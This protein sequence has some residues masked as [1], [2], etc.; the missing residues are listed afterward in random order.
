[1]VV[2]TTLKHV[3]LIESFLLKS[4]CVIYQFW[5]YRDAVASELLCSTEALTV[6]RTNK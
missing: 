6:L 1:M 2:H 3:C 5:V 4:S